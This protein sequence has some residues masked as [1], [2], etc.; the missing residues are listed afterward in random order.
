MVSVTISLDDE[1][2]AKIERFPWVNWSEI[3]RENVLKKEIFEK[4]IKTGTISDEDWEFCNMIDWH[5]VDEL[6][7]R[8]EFKKELEKR[9]RGPFIKLDSV[10]EIFE[11]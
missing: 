11:K 2:K 8:E 4:F 1:L 9:R 10:A 7:L 6:P 3:A 5:P